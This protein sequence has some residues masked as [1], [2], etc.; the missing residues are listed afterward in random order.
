[1]VVHK[2][3]RFTGDETEGCFDAWNG[4]ESIDLIQVTQDCDWRGV[5]WEGAKPPKPSN[6]PCLRGT[7]LFLSGLDVLLW[8]KGNVPSAVGG[9]NYYKEGKGIPSPLLLS[10]CAGHGHWEETCSQ[11]LGLTK[12]DWNNDSLYDS[13]PV[14]LKYAQTLARTLK[15]LPTLESR[16]YQ[17]RFFM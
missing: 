2:T 11:I 15:R 16:E 12:M 8:T 14:T 3:T 7:E 5:I 6:F 17:F 10:R 4:V 9:G 13:L 1:V